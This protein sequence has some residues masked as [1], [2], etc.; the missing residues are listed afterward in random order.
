[1][2]LDFSTFEYPDQTVD[3]FFE[4]VL[5]HKNFV[6]KSLLIRDFLATNQ[7]IVVTRPSKWG[8]SLNMDMLRLF[9]KIH[10]DKDGIP[11]PMNFA[12]VLFEGG[13]I[14]NAKGETKY[15]RPLKIAQ[16]YPQIMKHQGK[17]PVIHINS[18]VYFITGHP[19]MKY[20][21]RKIFLEDFKFL[22]K[23]FGKSNITLEGC[24]IKRF[25]N[26]INTDNDTLNGKEA[27]KLLI[28]VVSAHFNNSL[29]YLFVDEY[30]Y[31]SNNFNDCSSEDK[32]ALD[33]YQ[34]HIAILTDILKNIFRDSNKL[35]GMLTGI[36]IIPKREI[37]QIVDLSHIKED[38]VWQPY[39][40]DHYGFVE[41]EVNSL[42]SVGPQSPLYEKSRDI[43]HQYRGYVI[44]DKIIYN[45]FSI[46]Q[47]LYN[48]QIGPY[49]T[50]R[51]S[52]EE[53]I[54]NDEIIRDFITLMYSNANIIAKI[55]HRLTRLGLGKSKKEELYTHLL[56]YGFMTI[57]GRSEDF[58]KFAIP[59]YEIKDYIFHQIIEYRMIYDLDI[60]E[61]LYREVQ[62]DLSQI[63]MNYKTNDVEK[64]LNNIL[65]ITNTT[66][67][68]KNQREIM[69]FYDDIITLFVFPAT[70]HYLINRYYTTDKKFVDITFVPET[71][72]E[73][74]H[75]AILMRYTVVDNVEMLSVYSKRILNE[76]SNSSRRSD[77]ERNPIVMDTYCL[78][79]AL[80]KKKA[81]VEV[82]C[83]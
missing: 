16:Q 74:K 1:M 6:D 45:P 47:C 23:Y 2:D 5:N 31:F 24:D 80:Y 41:D 43:K 33:E 10:V 3:S 57:V 26:Y 59:T 55:T 48:G 12:R 8:K 79:I 62:Y 21:I 4:L 49:W 73:Q 56:M 42:L 9:L 51:E 63:L 28:D 34:R 44:G 29:V 53:D 66:C 54:F 18:M 38:T 64:C 46:M 77:I 75:H 50:D 67:A 11:L 7:T 37:S 35:R 40:I 83:P 61:L 25:E 72:E 39:F 69:K 27:F 14:R 17:Y 81:C 76:I 78:G 20:A 19:S 68:N 30:D 70:S 15:L 65:K 36:S 60:N 32:F 13:L 58:Y 82:A 52:L 71:A 22:T